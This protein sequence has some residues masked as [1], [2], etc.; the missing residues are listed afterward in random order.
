MKKQKVPRL[1]DL[2]LYDSNLSLNKTNKE[3]LRKV[4]EGEGSIAGCIGI[5]FMPALFIY[6]WIVD[7]GKPGLMD[8]DNETTTNPGKFI[9]A[10]QYTLN[11]L[12]H[13]FVNFIAD[14]LLYGFISVITGAVVAL[15][16]NFTFRSFF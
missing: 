1:W 2:P 3:D 8:I 15:I 6:F 12:P 7:Y 14:L 9:E 16:L 10:L 11:F 5:L 13:G 4:E